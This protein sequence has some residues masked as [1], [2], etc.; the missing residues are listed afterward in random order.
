MSN[1]GA[2]LTGPQMLLLPCTLIRGVRV[3]LG[4]SSPWSATFAFVL[5]LVTA[6]TLL[7]I[8]RSGAGESAVHTGSISSDA[9]WP[10]HGLA[11][12]GSVVR[13][14]PTPLTRIGVGPC[15]SVASSGS[16]SAEV[17]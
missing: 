12:A 8:H 9:S 2:V 4:T 15:E 1:H 14:I 10:V 3:F 6:W 17:S 16:A 5:L 7:T 11:W 13:T